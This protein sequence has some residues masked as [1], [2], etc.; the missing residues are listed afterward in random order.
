MKNKTNNK[1]T[2]SINRLL[3]ATLAEG[4]ATNYGREVGLRGV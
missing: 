2:I 4:A 1:Y 3:L